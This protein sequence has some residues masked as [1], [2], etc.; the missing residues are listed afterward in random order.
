MRNAKEGADRI[1]SRIELG[2]IVDSVPIGPQRVI[3]RVSVPYGLE[4]RYVQLFSRQED[5][6][7]SLNYVGL[8]AATDTPRSHRTDSA[9]WMNWSKDY[10]IVSDDIPRIN[11]DQPTIVALDLNID[12]CASVLATAA[13]ASNAY[14]ISKAPTLIGLYRPSRATIFGL[15]EYLA[16]AAELLKLPVCP[17]AVIMSV[18]FGV[19]CLDPSAIGG[20]NPLDGASSLSCYSFPIF[21]E[22]ILCIQ[23]QLELKPGHTKSASSRSTCAIFAAGGNRDNDVGLR[24]RLAYPALRPNVIAVT[25]IVRSDRADIFYPSE[26]SDLPLVHDLKPVF[27]LEPEL[28]TKFGAPVAGTS[29]AAPWCAAW[30]AALRTNAGD[31]HPIQALLATPLARMAT[32]QGLCRQVSISGTLDGERQ[33]SVPG[34]LLP[35]GPSSTFPEITNSEGILRTV[36]DALAQL[37][38]KFGDFELAITGSCAAFLTDIQ[39]NNST[40]VPVPTDVDVVYFGRDTLSEDNRNKIVELIRQ[41]V[42]NIF[43]MRDI[44]VELVCA[45]G[46][47][48]P[49]SL[50]QCII[51]ASSI[52]ITSGGVLDTWRG[53]EDIE[54]GSI[55]VIE[56]DP[57]SQIR[58]PHAPHAVAEQFHRLPSLLVALSLTCRLQ[59]SS[60]K[61][62]KGKITDLRES[63]TTRLQEIIEI[64]PVKYWND[65]TKNRIS[66]LALALRQHTV[67]TWGN[68]DSFAACNF[69]DAIRVIKESIEAHL[70]AENGGDERFA[71][72]ISAAEAYE[73]L[74]L[75]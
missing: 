36:S 49:F 6:S 54:S 22:A 53:Q 2:E 44:E 46:R 26:T 34:L 5:T 51:P 7:A 64:D 24:Q 8:P 17:D 16:L 4:M 50:F 45:E 71:E 59:V 37:N 13:A 68:G 27:G 65:R 42:G 72:Y 39:Y 52:L 63:W 11:S 70:N 9:K 33:R 1:G 75:N 55:R 32:L 57:E 25:H 69:R 62:G 41:S 66:K 38:E 73:R 58:H 18:D 56:P 40:A 12:H 74:Y 19:A 67:Y 31:S 48:A 28:A 60:V 47:I 29:F 10:Q 21:E 15:Y 20:M 23:S 3:E 30:Y 43:G 61:N 14:R 35:S